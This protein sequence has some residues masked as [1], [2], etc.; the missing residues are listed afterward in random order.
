VRRAGRT[1]A[2][3]QAQLQAGAFGKAMELL[4]AAEAGP[5]D[6]LQSAQLGWLLGQVA[7]ASGQGSDAPP[8]LLK[9]ARRFE[10][11]DPDL[12]RKTY[13]DAWQAAHIAGHLAS[14]GD[15]EGSLPRRPSAAPAEAAA[16]A[17]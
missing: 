2:A 12:A 17:G 7:F 13:L 5:L 11:L 4:D 10:P 9:A 6:E 16:A 15:L 3:A 1:L 8:L 14:G